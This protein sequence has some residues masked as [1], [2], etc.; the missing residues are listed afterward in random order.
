MRR[1]VWRSGGVAV[2]V[3]GALALAA[4][5]AEEPRRGG[6][7]RL[8]L[9]SNPTPNPITAP[10]G[11]SD[12][13]PNKTLFN[14]LV[15]YDPQDLTPRPDLAESW[16]Q[17]EDGLTWTFRLRKGVRWHDGRPFTADDV[18]FTLEAM[19]DK[20]VNARFRSAV[21]AVK[22]IEA[23]DPLTVRLHLKEPIA[24]LP[25]LLAYNVAIVP[26]HLLE[27]KDLN[28]PSE[29]LRR[30]VGTGPFRFQEAMSGDHFTV[31]AN[32]AY[33]E[34]RPSLDAVAFRI[35]PNL[36]TQIAQAKAGELDVILLDPP[37]LDAVKDVPHLEVSTAPVPQYHFVALNN[38]HPAFADRRVRQALAYGLDRSLI[39]D[40]VLQDKAE[41]ATGPIAPI[42]RWAY[43][44]NVK[45]YPFDPERAKAL[46]SEA[47]WKPGAG[48]VLHKDGKPLAF[49][50]L[51]DKGNPTREQIGTIA[52]QYWKRLGLDVKLEFGEWNTVIQRYRQWKYDAHL[53]WWF[54]APDPDLFP[55]YSQGGSNNRFQYANPEVDR[56]LREARAERDERKAARLYGRAQA[57]IVEDQP[58]VFLYYPFEIRAI[59]KRVRGFAPVGYRDALAWLHRVSLAQ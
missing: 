40:K 38:Q 26:R 48:G 36:N 47:G 55:Y 18:K 32:E 31:V 39:I 50:L 14:T 35:V 53:N 56:I 46:L 30:P 59:H 11:L 51:L 54:T 42:I 27:G 49:T 10:G 8:A 16:S 52:Q 20:K 37:Q 9:I 17:S 4:G 24:S 45:K 12:I 28:A 29:F 6:T 23:P 19:L 33:H 2:A 21:D 57:L 1:T 13:M 5:G 43:N 58:A 7:L 22:A 44:P 34:G 25:V 41:L 15:R 3:L